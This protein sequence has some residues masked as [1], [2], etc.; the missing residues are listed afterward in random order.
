MNNVPTASASTWNKEI[1]LELL[2]DK[3]TRSIM[4]NIYSS[5]VLLLS[6]SLDSGL[7]L[8]SKEIISITVKSLANY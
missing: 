8:L 1:N 3:N 2:L 5:K 7:L 4:G 6:Y